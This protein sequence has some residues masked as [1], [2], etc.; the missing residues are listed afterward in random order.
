MRLRVVHI[1]AGLWRDTGGPAEVIPNLCR[2]QVEAG[3]EVILCSIDGQ[4]A[5]QVVALQGSGVDV[6]LFPAL[7]NTLRYSPALA[8]S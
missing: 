4:N 1:V 5:P 6:Q 3:A 2:A 7:D 8:R